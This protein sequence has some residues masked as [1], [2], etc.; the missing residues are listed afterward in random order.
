MQAPGHRAVSVDCHSSRVRDDDGQFQC[1]FVDVFK[2]IGR[3][4]SGDAA[5]L[6][7]RWRR[8]V[9]IGSNVRMRKIVFLNS[10]VGI[11]VEACDSVWFW[12]QS[13]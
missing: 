9:A 6:L 12:A 8:Q 2:L 4:A 5:P 13:G 10:L 1:V 7:A 11:V 3:A